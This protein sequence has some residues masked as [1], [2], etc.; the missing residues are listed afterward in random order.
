MIA[1]S[2]RVGEFIRLRLLI[3]LRLFRV[4]KVLLLRVYSFV[5]LSNAKDIYLNAALAATNSHLYL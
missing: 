5:I 1:I 4:T 2:T 3:A